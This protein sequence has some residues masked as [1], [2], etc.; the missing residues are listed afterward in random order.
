[1]GEVGG[2]EKGGD[3]VEML[4]DNTVRRSRHEEKWSYKRVEGMIEGKREREDT[5][6]LY[7]R[8]EGLEFK[9]LLI[10]KQLS[11]DLPVLFFAVD[12]LHDE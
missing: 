1:M 4:D 10:A 7:N 2:E 6:V 3:G 9:L 5:F 11:P 12:I 8:R